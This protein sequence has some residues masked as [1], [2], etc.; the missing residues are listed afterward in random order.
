MMSMTASAHPF[1][2]I[3]TINYNQANAL[4]ETLDSIAGQTY[5]DFELLVIDGGSTDHS[6][7]VVSN[8]TS[9]ID[10][11]VSEPDRG[12]Y[13]AMN[14][15]LKQAKGTY[16]FFLN[17]GDTLT[18]NDSLGQFIRHSNFSGDI[19][20]GDYQYEKGHKRYPDQLTPTY[21]MKTSLPHQATLFHKKV[22]DQLGGYDESYAIGAD[23][24]FYI[25]AYLSGAF[26]FQHLPV[27]LTK[28]DLSGRSND[29]SFQQ[30]K[31]EEDLHMMR[32][33]YGNDFEMYWKQLQQ[34]RKANAVPKY[35]VKGIM[36]RVKKRIRALWKL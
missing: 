31:K 2:S 7:A 16:Y 13:H 35:S 6:K 34:E 11:W 26:Q 14:K 30:Q 4:Q 29:P 27:F 3:I 24:A 17:G 15:G 1:L 33:L 19:I 32:A 8:Y 12:I 23:R 9:L 20:Y 21:F 5:T 10:Y 18:S 25:K 36:K 22:F 28:F